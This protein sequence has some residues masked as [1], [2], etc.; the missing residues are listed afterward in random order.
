MPMNDETEVQ[1]HVKTEYFGHD[2]LDIKRAGNHVETDGKEVQPR[3]LIKLLE[4]RDSNHA[5]T[6]ELLILRMLKSLFF[7]GT[8]VALIGI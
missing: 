6:E 4:A 7:S 2:Q 5:R 1:Q 8:K 3:T